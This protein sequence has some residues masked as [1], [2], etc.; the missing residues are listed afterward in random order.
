MKLKKIV[1]TLVVL[2]V[3]K[4]LRK[5]SCQSKIVWEIWFRVEII[6]IQT[7]ASWSIILFYLN[8]NFGIKIYNRMNASLSIWK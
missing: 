7:A 3:L 1:I 6:T 2:K 4:D 8:E 5:L